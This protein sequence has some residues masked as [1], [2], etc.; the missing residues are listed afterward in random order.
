MRPLKT[1]SRIFINPVLSDCPDDQGKLLAY[2]T[3]TSTMKTPNNASGWD[4]FS[5]YLGKNSISISK[6]AVIRTRP[7]S[8]ICMYL[9]KFYKTTGIII[10]LQC[11]RKRAA[12]P[13]N[14]RKRSS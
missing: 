4:K 8:S 1:F 3:P 13:Q 10:H 14:K 9:R 12:D 6:N 11:Q 5:D 7:V 2:P